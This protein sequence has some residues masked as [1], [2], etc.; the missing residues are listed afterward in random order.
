MAPGSTV[1]PDTP[2]APEPA[3]EPVPEPAPPSSA[4]PETPEVQ[5]SA[6]TGTPEPAPPAEPVAQPIPP[7]EQRPKPPEQPAENPK[8]RVSNI[9]PVTEP[10]ERTICVIKRHRI[11]ILGVYVACGLVLMTTAALAFIVV[12]GAMGGGNSQAL[13]AGLA[14][15][16]MVAAICT[17]FALISAKVYWGNT[18]TLTT[19]SLTQVRRFNLFNR[20]S[21]QLSLKDLE[22]VTA[23]QNGILPDIFNYGLL[24][25]ET[26]GERSKFM[27]P[28]CPNPNYY[29]QQILKAR[30][31]FE[32]NRTAEENTPSKTP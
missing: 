19:D 23:E 7:P 3:P 4:Q 22:D 25:V 29:A 9:L 27:F 16:L 31:T 32:R 24:R 30:E 17:V 18:W 5:E 13:P 21:S 6:Q 14:A 11:G 1:T 10:G 8:K 28:F 15:F 26:A 20:Q 12:P 2:A